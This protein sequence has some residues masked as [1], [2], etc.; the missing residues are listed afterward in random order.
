MEV[1]NLLEERV[2]HLVRET[3]R[4]KDEYSRT[5]ASTSAI[6]EELQVLR[7]ENALLRAALEDEQQKRQ[8][9]LGR[10]DTLLGYLE[11][12]EQA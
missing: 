12:S 7:Q 6:E 10:I 5:L 1:L 11:E 4:A 2:G 8:E 3:M 9:V